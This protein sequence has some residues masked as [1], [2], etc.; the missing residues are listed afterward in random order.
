MN[1]MKN[2]MIGE[3]NVHPDRLDTSWLVLQNGLFCAGLKGEL[4]Q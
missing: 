4:W 2:G 1:F 3:S